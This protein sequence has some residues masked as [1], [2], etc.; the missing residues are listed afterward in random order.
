MP[1]YRED[2][3]KLEFSSDGRAKIKITSTPGINIYLDSSALDHL[4]NS[5]INLN[6]Y[7]FVLS[8]EAEAWEITQ[9]PPTG[10]PGSIAS[11]LDNIRGSVVEDNVNEFTCLYLQHP[12]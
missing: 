10:S 6:D 12:K 3:I 1:V 8:T 4:R 2:S 11:L 7:Y 9:H 5:G